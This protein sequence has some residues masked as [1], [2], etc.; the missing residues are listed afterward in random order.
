MILW[1]ILQD[2]TSK[3]NLHHEFILYFYFVCKLYY[4]SNYWNF[5]LK[6]VL[7]YNILTTIH[8][9]FMQ[10]KLNA[11]WLQNYLETLNDHP[12]LANI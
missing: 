3:Y 10:M 6:K 7:I 11:T 9:Q 8:D 2:P 1:G 5:D 4:L 12:K